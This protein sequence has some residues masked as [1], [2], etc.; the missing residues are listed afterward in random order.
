[1]HTYKERKKEWERDRQMD[2]G[3]DGQTDKQSRVIQRGT[4]EREKRE[5]NEEEKVKSK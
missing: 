4:R 2:C 1:M 3:T 5:R